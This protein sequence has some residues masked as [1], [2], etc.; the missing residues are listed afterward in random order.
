M[1]ALREIHTESTPHTLCN[2]YCVLFNEIHIL[3]LKPIEIQC[4][5]EASIGH[6]FLRLFSFYHSLFSDYLFIVE[7]SVL[8]FC[9]FSSTFDDTSATITREWLPFSA[10]LEAV[11]PAHE[12]DSV[13]SC[14]M[15]CHLEGSD[16]S[17]RCYT[18]GGLL[19]L[20]PLDSHVHSCWKFHLSFSVRLRWYL[21]LIQPG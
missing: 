8:P 14:L 4:N 21:R 15:P 10:V 19:C 5:H 3:H 1:K 7:N 9:H 2:V 13:C 18:V 11:M 20:T 12:A 6:T 16:C 17:V